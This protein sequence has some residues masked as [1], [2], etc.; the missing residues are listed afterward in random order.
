MF[1]GDLGGGFGGGQEGGRYQTILTALNGRPG[2]CQGAGI[3]GWV[4]RGGG[5]LSREEEKARNG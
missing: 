2:A 5:S 3:E 1:G 4:K